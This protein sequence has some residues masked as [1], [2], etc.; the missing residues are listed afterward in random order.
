MA[1]TIE[2]LNLG[3]Y[4]V[5]WSYLVKYHRPGVPVSTQVMSYLIQGGAEGPMLVDT[6]FRANG[7]GVKPSSDGALEEQ[8]LQRGIRPADIRY[9]LHTHLHHDH[10]GK[11]DIFPGSTTVIMNRRELEFGCS[12]LSIEEY[13]AVD[14]KHMIDRVH[15]PGAAWMLDLEDSGPVEIVPGVV[16]VSAGGHTEG[17]MNILVETDAGIACICGDLVTHVH[18]QLVAPPFQLNHR[19]P[20]IAGCSYVSQIHETAAI[21]RALAS[22]TWLLPS[23]DAPA[24]VAKGG[25]VTGRIGG[26]MVPGPVSELEAFRTT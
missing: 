16:A 12:G 18:E 13:A 25:L 3:S 17:S 19:E 24:R 4:D 2:I 7:S 5:D 11:D 6:G 23:H 9:V 1:L 15:T 8:L 10:A 14:M 20:R 26:A 21:K 22:C